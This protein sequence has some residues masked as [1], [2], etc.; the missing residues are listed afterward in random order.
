MATFPHDLMAD[1]R[2]W[3]RTYTALSAQPHDPSALRRHLILLSNRLWRHPHWRVCGRG[4]GRVELCR[5]AR[6][7]E[8]A[9]WRES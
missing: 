5:Q 9:P 6:I 8:A 4:P 7:R 2:E 3:Q 1:Q